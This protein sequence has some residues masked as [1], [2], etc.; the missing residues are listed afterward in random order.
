MH[1][2]IADDSSEARLVLQTNLKKWGYDVIVA[3][4]GNDA[5]E[6]LSSDNAPGIA[7]LD[8][9]MPGMEG[10]EICRG[11]RQIDSDAFTYLILLTANSKAED[12]A[13]GFEAGADD[14]I[15][16]PCG[17]LEL[18]S[19]VRAAER[20]VNLEVFLRRKI[21]ELEETISDKENLEKQIAVFQQ[22]YTF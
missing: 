6:V 20:I 12:L 1:V 5:W 11:V 19:R 7:I 22:K 9:D 14:Y 4:D 15:V 21:R 8:W 2:L 17:H 16:K 10:P 3:E 18:R 13:L